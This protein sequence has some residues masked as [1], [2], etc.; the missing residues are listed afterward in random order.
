MG[1]VFSK[2]A[3][4]RVL[5]VGLDGSGKTS[6]LFR[7]KVGQMLPT[8]PTQGWHAQLVK[9]GRMRFLFWD[10][11]GTPTLRPLWRHHYHGTHAVI[12]VV[13]AA[14]CGRLEEAAEALHL[15]MNDPELRDAV[16]LVLANKQDV[17]GALGPE[18][19]S[20]LLHL[21]PLCRNGQRATR[22]QATSAVYGTGLSE[23]IDWLSHMFVALRY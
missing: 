5:I 3:F 9:S 8:L 1:G 7:L 6:L 22:V 16:L 13:D 23:T 15:V 19:V 10:V 18:E 4:V 2:K 11:G 17:P 14:D 20:R 21:E 12:F